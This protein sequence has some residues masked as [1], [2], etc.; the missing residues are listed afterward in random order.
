MGINVKCLQIPITLLKEDAEDIEYLNDNIEHK[1]NGK[2]IGII[3]ICLKKNTERKRK[4]KR[5]VEEQYCEKYFE[6]LY[7]KYENRQ[8]KKEQSTETMILF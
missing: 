3:R 6:K 4:Q 5:Q 1:S 7:A 8:S 2:K